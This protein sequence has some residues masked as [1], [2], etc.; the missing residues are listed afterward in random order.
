[1]LYLTINNT[2]IRY[3]EPNSSNRHH[4]RGKK[5]R[6]GDGQVILQGGKITDGHNLNWQTGDQEHM[7]EIEGDKVEGGWLKLGSLAVSLGKW[8]A[9]N[10]ENLEIDEK[11]FFL[12]QWS[13]IG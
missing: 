3:K 8:T 9:Q 5:G 12:Q 10:R 6:N 1:M 2:K 11:A 13:E 7:L 4:S